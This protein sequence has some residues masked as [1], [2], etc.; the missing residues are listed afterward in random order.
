MDWV[1][2]LKAGIRARL[3][4][5]VKETPPAGEQILVV[6]RCAKEQK[7]GYPGPN[8]FTKVVI[9]KTL[10]NDRWICRKNATENK[11]LHSS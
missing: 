8:T 1:K 9:W 11:T 3:V 5:A 4:H 6:V 2:R 10:E 7:P